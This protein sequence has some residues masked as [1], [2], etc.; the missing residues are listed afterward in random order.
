MILGGVIG[1]LLFALGVFEG[2]KI[3]FF[4]FTKKTFLSFVV[5][6]ETCHICDFSVIARIA[7][8]ERTQRPDARNYYG[9]KVKFTI[10]FVSY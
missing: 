8:P 3:D 6:V 1:G 4:F 9:S 5:F 10:T 7:S 2:G